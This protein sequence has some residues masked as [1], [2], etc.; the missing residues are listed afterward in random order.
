[1][2]RTHPIIV[3]GILVLFL[4][5]SAI[6]CATTILSARAGEPKQVTATRKP[7]GTSLT[8]I[9]KVADAKYARPTSKDQQ[10]TAMI[11]A[12]AWGEPVNGLRVAIVMQSPAVDKH[13]RL[14]YE[15][16]A[17]NTSDHDIRF[18]ATVGSSWLAF[19]TIELVDGDGKQMPEQQ[20]MREKW[21]P[22]LIRFWLKPGERIL[23]SPWQTQLARVEEKGEPIAEPKRHYVHPFFKVT[24]GK[25]SV[26]ATVE[27]G[28]S[29][30]SLDP[31]S[32]T[33]TV[34]SPAQGEWS[35][36]LKTGAVAVAL[37]MGAGEYRQVPE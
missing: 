3:L 11:P 7:A 14:C 24:P 22:S 20:G 33:K 31:A 27:L 29:M 18:A 37:F 17:E 28:P 12:E 30:Y 36:K 5:A 32:G 4:S 19:C 8:Q 34:L 9:A 1:M 10:A 26:S 23:I 16:V 21:G 35:G 6:L 25:Y 13:D 2:T 15:I